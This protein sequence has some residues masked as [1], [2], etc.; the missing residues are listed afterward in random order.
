MECGGFRA[1]FWNAPKDFRNAVEDIV[2]LLEYLRNL[3]RNIRQGTT[4]QLLVLCNRTEVHNQLLQHGF[5]TFWRGGLRVSTSSS[6][7]DATALIAVLSKQVCDFLGGG[8]RGATP[9]D[10]EDCFGRAT[11]VLCLT[12]AIQHTHMVS[13]VH[14]WSDH[15]N[16]YHTLKRREVQFHGTAQIPTDAAAMLDWGLD[17]LH[18]TRPAAIGNCH[19]CHS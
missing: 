11:V 1:V 3:H 17:T 10:R 2:V 9:D 6:A 14:G 16:G 8:R 5:Q 7:A 4:S 15:A 12:R 13:P 18:V 19:D